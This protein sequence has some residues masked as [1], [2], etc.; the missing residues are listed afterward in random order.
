MKGLLI[1]CSIVFLAFVAGTTVYLL[2][3]S[4]HADF[5]KR[6]SHARVYFKGQLSP[7]S[8]LYRRADGPS[9]VHTTEDG[10]WYVI[11]SKEGPIEYCDSL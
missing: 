10:A 9:I 1:K 3:A 4:K 2:T 5:W 11:D 6:D 8:A 7:G